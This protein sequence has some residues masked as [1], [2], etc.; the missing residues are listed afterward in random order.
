LRT[1]IEEA[2]GEVPVFDVLD[3]HYRTVELISR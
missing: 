1:L 3:P 2:V